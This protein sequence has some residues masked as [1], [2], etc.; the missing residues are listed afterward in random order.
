MGVA[1]SPAYST[2]PS[3]LLTFASACPSF[4]I[5]PLPSD[6][7][8]GSQALSTCFLFSY[9]RSRVVALFCG[10]TVLRNITT[11]PV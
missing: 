4:R 6:V 11:I 8:G 9:A 2:A 7:S 10:P 5:L 3:C 1:V